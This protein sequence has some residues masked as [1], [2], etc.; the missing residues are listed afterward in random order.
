MSLHASGSQGWRTLRNHK[1]QDKNH[2][3]WQHCS[4]RLPRDS[5]PSSGSIAVLLKLQH[6]QINQGR[7]SDG[8]N[9]REFCNALGLWPEEADSW[10]AAALVHV[11]SCCSFRAPDTSE[12]RWRHIVHLDF[13]WR[14]SRIGVPWVRE[15]KQLLIRRAAR[16]QGVEISTW[17]RHRKALF[18][19]LSKGKGQFSSSS[20]LG[21]ISEVS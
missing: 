7:G 11:L 5:V 10:L 19:S 15:I 17:S 9:G 4:P 2:V 20:S 18:S 16:Q 13:L 14:I 21:H 12:M 8:I 1:T 6:C 3:S